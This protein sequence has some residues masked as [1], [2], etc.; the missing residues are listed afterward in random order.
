MDKGTKNRQKCANAC[1]KRVGCVAFD[2][3]PPDNSAADKEDVE[4]VRFKIDIYEF[5]I[6]NSKVEICVLHADHFKAKIVLK[7]SN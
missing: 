6:S 3:S 4:K 5:V 2:L 1:K 7:I